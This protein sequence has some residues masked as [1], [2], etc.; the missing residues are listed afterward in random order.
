MLTKEKATLSTLSTRK[1]QRNF[2]VDKVDIVAFSFVNM[3]Y[4]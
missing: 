3:V 1:F 4:S 2:L